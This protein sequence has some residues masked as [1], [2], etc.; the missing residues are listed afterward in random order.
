MDGTRTASDGTDLDDRLGRSARTDVARSYFQRAGEDDFIEVFNTPALELLENFP[1]R[2]LDIAF[3]AANEG[4]YR[5]YLELLI[6][7]LKLSGLLFSTTLYAPQPSSPK[8]SCSHPD[9][10]AT[11]LALDDGIAIG[12]RR[13]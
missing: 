3:V 8:R 11:M 6:P 7:M 1:H 2:N 12:A 10:D 5:A 4:E 13:K 9:L